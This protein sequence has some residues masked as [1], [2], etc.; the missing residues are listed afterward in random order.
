MIQGGLGL[1][2]GGNINPSGVSMFEPIHGSAPKYKG[3][4][5]ANPVA[6]ILAGQLMLDHLGQ[7]VAAGLVDQAVTDVLAR[8]EIRTRDL[9]GT[10]STTEMGDAVVAR[11]RELAEQS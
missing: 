1:A 7:D 2:P 4:N 5:V 9:G 11:I 6:T 10:N 3:Q 8:R